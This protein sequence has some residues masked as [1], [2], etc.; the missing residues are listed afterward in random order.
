[1]ERQKMPKV[2][3]MIISFLLCDVDG[4]LHRKHY[5]RGKEGGGA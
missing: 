5:L 4:E 3:C 2:I 1:M